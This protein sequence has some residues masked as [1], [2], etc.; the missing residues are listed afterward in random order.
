MGEVFVPAIA[1]ALAVAVEKDE[2]IPK[3]KRKKRGKWSK[4]RYH[5]DGDF[6]YIKTAA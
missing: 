6:G 4:D 3:K 2:C 5:K 1:V